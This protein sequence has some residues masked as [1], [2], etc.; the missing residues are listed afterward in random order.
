M[1][2]SPKAYEAWR[3]HASAQKTLADVA[4]NTY[5]LYVGADN[6]TG[7]LH[8]EH[9]RRILDA[10]LDGYT[11]QWATGYWHGKSEMSAVITITASHITCCSIITTIKREL[12]QEAVGVVQLPGMDFA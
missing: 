7:N 9:L 3:A 2:N 11:L 4:V 8:S 10:A 12:R 6:E 1:G 5:Q